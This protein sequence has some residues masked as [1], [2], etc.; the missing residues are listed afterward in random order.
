MGKDGIFVV[1]YPMIRLLYLK[2]RGRVGAVSLALAATIMAAAPADAANA[3][4]Q[5]GLEARQDVWRS[6]QTIQRAIPEAGD[7]P[8]NVYLLGESVSIRV[9]ADIRDKTAVRWQALDD[10]GEVVT[11][12]A[13]ERID[14]GNEPTVKVGPLGIGWYRIEFL[15][16]ESESVG[17]TT[18]AVLARLL[19]PVPQ[20]SP[21][22]VDSAT[23]WFAKDNPANQTHLARLAALA[24]VNW[25][26]DRMQ[27]R[28]VQ[29]GP[30]KFAENTTY[31]SAAEIQT[32]MG[33][34]VLQVFHDTPP[35][36]IEDASTRT[37]LPCD[38]R[39]LYRFCKAM[40]Q[41][42]KGRVLAWEPWNEANVSDFGAHTVDQMCVHQKAA[43][44]GFKSGDPNVTVCWNAVAAA[45]TD[46][47][48]QGVLKN[49]AWPYFDTYNIH[50]YDWPH[51]YVD[52]W[53]PVR[54]AACGRPIWVTESDRGIKYET[55]PPWH[56][57]SRRNERLKSE[58][59]AQ[60]YASSLFAGANRHFHFVLGHYTESR[61]G[62]QFGLLRR[63][64]T[65]RPGY[66]AL[67]AVGRFLAGAK[68]LGRWR[69]DGKPDA[70]VIA[71]GAT[72]DGIDRDV[73]VAWN[74][75]KVDWAERGRASVDWPPMNEV[76]VEGVFDY[77]GRSLGKS[78]PKKLGS[79]PTFLVLPAGEAQKLPL[80][81]PPALSEFRKG[82]AQP[83]V[84]QIQ[85]PRS[86]IKR[87]EGVRWAHEYEYR[88]KPNVRTD[89]S[90]Y[91][92]NFSNESVT[93]TVF[94]ENVPEDWAFSP[95]RWE[96]TIKPME[97]IPLAAHVTISPRQ[98][99]KAADN[100]VT[101]RGN[102]TPG[103]RPVLA[104]RLVVTE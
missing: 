67:A 20:E 58:F 71:F 78:V 79:S 12:G 100:W 16:A 6:L 102:L 11:Q 55:S 103:G 92:Y 18:A 63:D 4:Q 38:L 59:I 37:Q 9:P 23:A 46:L 8:G 101:L 70:Q 91:A 47:H 43:Y 75:R 82:T 25:I 65:P 74:E 21:V 44:L 10:R 19:S 84:L 13:Y 76:A 31:D 1:Y 5:P 57:L 27:W 15:D 98:R 80:E 28:E 77:L 48:T 36:A 104:F 72:P 2:G 24:G 42:Y 85:M 86:C 96:I 93:G 81:S 34:K 60:S 95:D 88:I 22:C 69:L 17:W 45:P 49:E 33:L 32:R 54:K 90:I 68:C 14:A 97:Q 99:E 83:V 62:V 73:L 53:G 30:D 50:T 41:R 64:Y 35:W 61:N 56:E 26:R 7:H 39:V 52:L 87:V 89:L 3:E 66:V 94:V 40:A 29:I 51:S